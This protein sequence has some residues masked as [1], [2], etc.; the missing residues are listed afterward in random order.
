MVNDPAI[1][2]ARGFMES[3]PHAYVKRNFILLTTEEAAEA[4]ERLVKLIGKK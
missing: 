4:R 3:K 2:K 1:S